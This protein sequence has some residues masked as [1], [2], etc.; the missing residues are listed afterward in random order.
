VLLRVVFE[1]LVLAAVCLKH[2]GFQEEFEWRAIYFPK[3]RPSPLMETSIQT[4]GG[5]PQTVH[6]IP[7]DVRTSASAI[8]F[9]IGDTSTRTLS[10]PLR[11]AVW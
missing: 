2:E 9:T 7:L 8:V 11:C 4:V 5:I 3:V 6:A 1:T 10:N